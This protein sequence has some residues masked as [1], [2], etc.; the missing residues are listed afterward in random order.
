MDYTYYPGCS[1]ES[2]ARMY[3]VSTRA[4]FAALGARLI[5]LED[6][7]CCGA[8]A[9]MSVSDRL[10]FAISAR[11]LALAEP[12]GRDLVTPCSG[13]F[14][15]L[16]KTNNYLRDFPQCRKFV[17][18]ALASAGLSYQGTQ[19]VRHVLDV[20]VN[21]IGYERIRAAVKRPLSGV[22]VACYYGCQ[23]V[24]PD[25]GLDHPEEPTI[26]ERFVEALG[27]EP[28]PHAYKTRCCG[29][30][31]MGTRPELALRMAKN[32]LL[33]ARAARADVMI[34]A[35]PL[36]QLN[37]DAYQRDINREFELD[38]NVPV[39]YFTQ[40]LGL[41]LGLSP[42]ELMLDDLFVPADALLAAVA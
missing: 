10:S 27:A 39:I 9:Y 2:T 29:G 19:R 11:N 4:T 35:C 14:S 38:L 7:N 25:T 18:T 34:A 13:C 33:P 37:L 42:E 32:C 1:E 6:W 41:A 12:L 26:M 15:V 31:L 24:R 16:V 36:C 21:D 40:L 22:K 8:T 23:L 20:L 3:D 17:D 30:S 5:E 28:R